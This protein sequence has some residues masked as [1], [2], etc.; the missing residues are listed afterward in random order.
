MADHGHLD[1]E[2]HGGDTPE[3]RTPLVL[4]WSPTQPLN[5]WPDEALR[6]NCSN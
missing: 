3:E 5:A 1:G 4:R 6:T 2:G